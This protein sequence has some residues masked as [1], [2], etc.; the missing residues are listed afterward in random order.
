MLKQGS[1]ALLWR[2]RRNA[3]KRRSDV[4]EAW[5]GVAAVAML[6]LSAPTVSVVAA[7]SKA[8][9]STTV[10]LDDVGLVQ[11]A[12][13]TPAQANSQGVAFGAAAAAGTGVLVVGGW[14]AARARLD[15][16]RR[17]QWELAW[18]EPDAHQGHRHA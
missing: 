11:P 12:P 18:A 9:A 7:G 14:W 10:C 8:G 6:L 16:R 17:A 13:P 4:V 1:R 5:L 3:L 2:W 15:R